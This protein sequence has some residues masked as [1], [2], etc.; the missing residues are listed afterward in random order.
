MIITLENAKF[1]N[2]KVTQSWLDGIESA[3]RELTNNNFQV[4]AMRVQGLEF[5]DGKIVLKKGNIGLKEN[6]TIQVSG[7]AV[8]DGVYTIKNV[9]NNALI[10]D[11]DIVIARD[12]PLSCVTF[13]RYPSDIKL[14]VEKLLEYDAKMGHKIGIKSEMLSRHSV[15][16]FDQNASESIAG[17]PAAL[18][19]FLENHRKLR[20]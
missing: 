14:G 3:I 20:W 8:N 19:K 12:E 1:L 4:P 13:V 15:S 16:Y 18:M 9:E 10:L 11:N 2:P 17:Y 6:D 5:Y 7:S